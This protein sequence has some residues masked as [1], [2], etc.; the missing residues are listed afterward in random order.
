M[1]PGSGRRRKNK[2]G[3]EGRSLALVDVR[4]W[5]VCFRACLRAEGQVEGCNKKRKT[6]VGG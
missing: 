2:G 5:T 4:G 6:N 3:K 1:E